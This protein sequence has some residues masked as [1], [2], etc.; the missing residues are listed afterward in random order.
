MVEDIVARFILFCLMT[1]QRRIDG[2]HLISFTFWIIQQNLCLPL[3]IVK[4][5]FYSSKKYIL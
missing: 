3:V 2:G 5:Q 4:F 1:Y